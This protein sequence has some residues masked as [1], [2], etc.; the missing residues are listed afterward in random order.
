MSQRG[1]EPQRAQSN[2]SLNG[3]PEVDQLYT[4][5]IDGLKHLYKTKMRPLEEQYK[6]VLYCLLISFHER[7]NVEL[8]NEK[9]Y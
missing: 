4:S 5:V 8:I 3:N 7:V 1:R 2:R 9:Y 6:Y